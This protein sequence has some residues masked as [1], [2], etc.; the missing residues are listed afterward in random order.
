ME[1]ITY[2]DHPTQVKYWDGE[3]YIG[4]IGFGENIICGCCGGIVPLDEV[5]DFAEDL[6]ENTI[7]I[8]VFDM[9]WIDIS[10]SILGD[11]ATELEYES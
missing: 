8:K 10:D 3:S 1:R 4:G 9:E 2:F 7:L 5:Y 11:E 6:K